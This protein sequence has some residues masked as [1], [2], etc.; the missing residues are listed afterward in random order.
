MGEAGTKRCVVAYA[1]PQ[2]QYLWT[3]DLP[4]A[5]TVSDALN[6]A[7]G[8]A[9][10]TRTTRGTRQELEE[11]PW[12]TA[13]V[14]IFGLPCNRQAVPGDGD[15]VEIYRPLRSDPRERRRERV[16]SERRAKQR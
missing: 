7:R 11:I 12:D 10:E 14:G 1:T 4:A 3:V 13:P 9:A 8:L 15:R 6:A 5:A 16:R 2:H